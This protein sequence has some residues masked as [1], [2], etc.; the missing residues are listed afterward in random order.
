MRSPTLLIPWTLAA[1]FSTTE[2]RAGTYVTDPLTS[3]SFAG[4]GSRGG[5]FGVFAL[6]TFFRRRVSRLM[7]IENKVGEVILTGPVNG[8][9]EAMIAFKLGLAIERAGDIV[10]LK[11]NGKS[12]RLRHAVRREAEPGDLDRIHVAYWIRR[13]DFMP[14]DDLPP[15]EVESEEGDAFGAELFVHSS[16]D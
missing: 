7:Q 5:S 6:R 8:S 10:T 2:A 12:I 4:R 1:V 15:R 11:G 3:A 9:T 14:A 13:A 16:H